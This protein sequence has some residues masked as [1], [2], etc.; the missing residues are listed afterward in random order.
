ML[1]TLYVVYML[2]WRGVWVGRSAAGQRCRDSSGEQRCLIIVPSAK[3]WFGWDIWFYEL[4]HTYHRLLIVLSQSDLASWEPSMVTGLEEAALSWGM[5]LWLHPGDPPDFHS[6]VEDQ[7]ALS[8]KNNM[9][10]MSWLIRTYG[11]REQSCQYKHEW[12]VVCSVINFQ[13]YSLAVVEL[14]C[15]V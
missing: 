6:E 10:A 13:G 4:S 12:R 7:R 14:Y 9:T 15:V 3:T 1:F 5:K 8:G 11:R 2:L